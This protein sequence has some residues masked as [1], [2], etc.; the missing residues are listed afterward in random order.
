MLS[1]AEALAAAARPPPRREGS[2]R[3]AL[4]VGAGGA[5][6]SAVLEE[7][8]SSHRY[9]RVGVLALPS[10]QPALRGLHPVADTADALARFAP[11]TA[12]IVFDRLRHANGREAALVR[13]SPAELLERARQ[14]FLAGARTLVVVVPHAPALLPHALKAGLASLDEAGVAVL[15]FERLVFMRMAQAGPANASAVSLPQRVAD[16]MLRQLQWMI[17]QHEQPV[18]SATVARVACALALQLPEAQPG[19][20]VLPP[21]VLALAAQGADARQ[22]TADWLA[23]RP[24]QA[25][26]A[27]PLRL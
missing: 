20:R 16:W 24:L 21:E 2:A 7:L 3:R 13:P 17:P 5:L 22:L 11:D 6:G 15:G 8:L 9:A 27:K 23:G 26:V 1:P 18:R 4:L 25:P 14:L 10:L 19:T 12:L